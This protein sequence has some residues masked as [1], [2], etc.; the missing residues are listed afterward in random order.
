MLTSSTTAVVFF[1]NDAVDFRSLLGVAAAA[2]CLSYVIT[3]FEKLRQWV[4]QHPCKAKMMA[5]EYVPASI[6]IRVSNISQHQ[7][8]SEY[9]HQDLADHFARVAESHLDKC[10]SA[11]CDHRQDEVNVDDIRIFPDENYV[12]VKFHCRPGEIHSCVRH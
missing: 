11:A 1:R 7:L 2:N 8:Q 4:Q 10:V 12:T 5:V 9:C 6:C 3:E